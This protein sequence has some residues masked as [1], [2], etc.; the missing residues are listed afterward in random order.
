MMS[1]DSAENKQNENKAVKEDLPNEPTPEAHSKAST[2]E[3]PNNDSTNE[4]PSLEQRFEQLEKEYLYLRAELENVKRQNLKER[5]QLLKYGAER[6]ARD[7]LD[8]LDVFKSALASEITP[9]NFQD[10]VKGVEMTA[11]SLKTTLEKHGISEVDCIG[12][13]FDPNTQEAL[14]SEPSD[15]YPEG[16]VTQVFK[17][18]YQYHDK[19]LRPGQVVV[20]RAKND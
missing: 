8:T 4:A 20:S 15:E 19:L 6:L 2:N 13:A 14:S 10:F 16:H 11:S 12:Q 18:P 17:S 1:S 5:S 7:L 3:T 9:E